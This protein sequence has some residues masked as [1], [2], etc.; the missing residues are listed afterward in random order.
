MLQSHRALGLL[1]ISDGRGPQL[2]QVPF[3]GSGRVPI[4]EP[5][6]LV[7][8]DPLANQVR[9]EIVPPVLLR[10]APLAAPQ[11]DIFPPSSARNQPEAEIDRDP[12]LVAL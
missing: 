9:R 5:T 6:G 3:L 8:L 10:L 4:V 2:L 12:W 1:I 7:L 11:V